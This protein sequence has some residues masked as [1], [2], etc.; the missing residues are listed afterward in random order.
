MKSSLA[1]LILVVSK[2]SLSVRAAAGRACERLH[3]MEGMSAG[4]AALLLGL[5][6]VCP[7]AAK[8][9]EGGGIVSGHVQDQS[10]AAIVNVDVT[11]SSVQRNAILALKSNKDGTYT[12]PSLP[13]GI[14][15]ISVQSA[16]FQP[17]RREGIEV[18]VDAH[19]Q[20]DFELKAGGANETVSVTAEGNRVNTSSVEL[21]TVISS[22]PIQELPIN[23]RSVLALTQLTPGVTSAAGQLNEG[24]ADRGTVVSSVSINNAPVG[25]NAVLIDGQS[26]VQTYTGEDSLNPTSDAVEEFKIETGTISA[27]YGY[28]A[29][30]AV[31]MVSRSGTDRYHGSIYEFF[32]NDAL[33]ARTYFNRY[34]QAVDALRYNQFGGTFGGSIRRRTTV[35]GNYEEYRYL[36]ESTTVASVPTDAWKNGDFSQ[37][38]G[39]NGKLIPIYDPA[40][41]AP[42]PSGNG[43]VRQQFQ[44]NIIP[45]NRLDPVAKAVNAFYPEPNCTPTNQYTQANNYCGP[46]ENTRWM[47]QFIVRADHSFSQRHTMFVRYGYYKAYTDSGGGANGAFYSKIEPFLGRRYDND[48]NQAGILE[49]TFVISP[50]W[51]NEA[52]LSVLRTDFTFV[53]SS[54][55]QNWPSKLGMPNVPEETFPRMSNG[56]STSSTSA[57]GERVPRTLSFPTS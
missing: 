39:T 11:V 50:T 37:Y 9:Q 7:G 52:R 43:Y 14:Y 48:P 22:R 24:F 56:F 41:T 40:T 3:V 32:C 53:T 1:A 54:Y 34:P 10:G 36:N 26:I 23:G 6:L 33:D 8:A 30:G 13:I 27:E 44:G 31:S 5:L 55:N 15:S 17:Q 47:R 12:T 38:F 4:G 18:Q 16:G 35:F 57:V 49:D 25:A 21:G 51:V 46:T 29:G 19:L 42:N 20:V 45:Q 28:L 2:M